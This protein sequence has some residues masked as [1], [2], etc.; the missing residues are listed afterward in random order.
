M[1]LVKILTQ[2]VTTLVSE[3][4]QSIP[5]A[6]GRGSAEAGIPLHRPTPL[7][8]RHHDCIDLNLITE[9]PERGLA[10]QQT[11]D[12]V[13]MRQLHGHVF[14]IKQRDCNTAEN[15]PCEYFHDNL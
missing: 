8:S 1:G 15:E 12:R 4:K 9:Y 2:N 6:V 11:R 14:Y 3:A 13:L 7:L 5:A 10:H